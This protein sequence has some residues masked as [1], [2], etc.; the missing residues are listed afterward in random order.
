MRCISHS[1]CFGVGQLTDPY[2][3]L[4]KTGTRGWVIKPVGSGRIGLFNG[5]VPRMTWTDGT[6][7]FFIFRPWKPFADFFHHEALSAVD[8]FPQSKQNHRTTIFGLWIPYYYS[9]KTKK[10]Y[11]PY[12]DYESHI[13]PKKTHM[14]L[15]EIPYMPNENPMHSS[16]KSH[17]RSSWNPLQKLPEFE[18]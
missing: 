14:V 16:Y 13:V 4:R 5:D 3:P 17:L 2:Q 1:C 18:S 9:E 6:I 8:G 11:G 15:M 12:L 7:F 10:T